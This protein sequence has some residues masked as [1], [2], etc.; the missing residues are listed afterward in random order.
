MDYFRAN[1]QVVPLDFTQELP[2]ETE[3][4]FAKE[5]QELVGPMLSMLPEEYG[6]PLYLSDIQGLPQKEI[7]AKL[8]L[9]LSGTK[10]RIQ[11]G[12]EKLKA[13]FLE[14]CHLEF[15]RNGKLLQTQVRSHCKPLQHLLPKG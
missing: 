7:A 14:C 12:R 10:S 5:M 8:N 9:S 1:K 2:L 15:D 4:S 6:Q 13:L 3:A 11:R